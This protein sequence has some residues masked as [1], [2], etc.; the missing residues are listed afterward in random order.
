MSRHVRLALRW[1]VAL[2]A[3]GHVGSAGA[4]ITTIHGNERGVWKNNSVVYAVVSSVEPGPGAR[5]VLLLDVRA[6][7]TG[8]FDPVGAE[9][10]VVPLVYGMASSVRGYPKANSR[11]VVVL[12]RL[13]DGRYIVPTS[14]VPFMPSQSAVTEVKSFEDPAVQQ[15]LTRLREL[16][17]TRP[18]YE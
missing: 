14:R 15:I 10:L 18:R 9:S 7:L 11:I 17:A 12:R 6:T 3:V 2:L 8:S 13:E 4:G 1:I 5:A 16:R